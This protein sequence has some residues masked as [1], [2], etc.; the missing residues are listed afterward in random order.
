MANKISSAV[1]GHFRA[2]R[3]VEER[4]GSLIEERKLSNWSWSSV[5]ESLYRVERHLLNSCKILIELLE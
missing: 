5:S 1:M 4:E 3:W 2:S